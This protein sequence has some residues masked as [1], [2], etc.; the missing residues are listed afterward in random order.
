MTK[1]GILEFD[2]DDHDAKEDFKASL[3]GP[4]YKMKIDSLY[5]DVFRK[6]T[7]YNVWGDTTQT[8]TDDEI[9]ECLA[10]MGLPITSLFILAF[11]AGFQS[12]RVALKI[13]IAKTFK[14]SHMDWSKG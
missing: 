6:M 8:M 5:D 7:K 13:K 10:A 11:R 12:G 14:T 9:K 2:L 1:S 4:I 3:N